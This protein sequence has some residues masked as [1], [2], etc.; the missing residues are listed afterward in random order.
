MKNKQLRIIAY[1]EY[2]AAEANRY[3]TTHSAK[4]RLTNVL[5]IQR[6]FQKFRDGNETLVDH[7]GHG[8]KMTINNDRIRLWW[9]SVRELTGDLGGTIG[10][11]SNH[12]KELGK[13]KSWT[14]GFYTY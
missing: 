10:T 3:I 13:S 7:E 1:K 5:H 11:I 2:K 6:G 4:E 12:L 9:G 8:R 14:S